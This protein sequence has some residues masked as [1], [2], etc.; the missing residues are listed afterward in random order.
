M[1][2]R[3]R[4][5]KTAQ[6][7]PEAVPAALQR[8]PLPFEVLMGIL[9]EAF[10]LDQGMAA[11]LL[12]LNSG[13]RKALHPIVYTR[14]ELYTSSA[15]GSFAQLVRAHPDVARTVRAVWIGPRTARSDLLSILSVPLPGD[16]AY[17]DQLRE[18]VYANT[19]LV[20]RA[21]RRLQDVALSGS[22]VS[23]AIVH[24]YG[25]A[26]QP[27]RLTSVNPHSFICGFDA[28]I[29]RK[30]E[31]LTICDI[32]LSVTEAEAIRRLPALRTL[33]Y[34]SPK[35]Y[36]DTTRDV[37]VL[38]KLLALDDDELSI[39][40]H[41]ERLMLDQPASRIAHLTYRAASERAALVVS[42]L[43]AAR[44]NISPP[45]TLVLVPAR[46]TPA[47]VDEW[48]ALRDLVFNAQEEYSRTA[49]G[50]DVGSWVDPSDA[51]EMLRL[52]WR[53]RSTEVSAEPS[54]SASATIR[55]RQP[56]NR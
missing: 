15:L 33:Q 13:I 6:T 44:D 1:K 25:T 35:D 9:H 29:F 53:Q 52:E 47:F 14:V 8:T 32:N 3:S 48:E 56:E 50:D 4:P 39:E 49:L 21:C 45:R 40:E 34:T 20:L 26:C 38:R 36:G 55:P 37:W 27:V 24:S 16:S 51:L 5:R 43:E 17:L 18:E 12:A 54:A 30:V 19:R 46:L 31:S 2:R 28:P 10:L 7:A 22:L 11:R 23:K 42:S 41:L